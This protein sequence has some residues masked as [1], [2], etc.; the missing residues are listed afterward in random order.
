MV[1]MRGEI[2]SSSSTI[3]IRGI[4]A[5]LLPEISFTDISFVDKR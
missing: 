1:A 4:G 2:I 3:R 5:M